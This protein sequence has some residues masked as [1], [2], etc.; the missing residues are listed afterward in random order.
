[1]V[2]LV[3][4]KLGQGS[5]FD[6]CR[7]ITAQISSVSRDRLLTQ[8]RGSLPPAPVLAQIYRNWR[9]LYQTFYCWQRPDSGDSQ[10]S[11]LP[12]TR[13][14][15]IQPGGVTHFSEVEFY[16][17]CQQFNKQLNQ[18]LN[19]E[20]F[21]PIYRKIC[22]ELDADEEIRLILETDDALLRQIPWHLW[23]FFRD[24]PKAE[25][26]LSSLEYRPIQSQA[27]KPDRR[28]KILGILGNSEGIDLNA[29]RKAIEDLPGATPCFLESPSHRQF[30]E[31]LWDDQWDI[32]FFAGHSQTE[33]ETGTGRIQINEVTSLSLEQLRNA[34][35]RA[36]SRGLKLAIFNSCDGLGLAKELADLDLPQVIVMREQVPDQVAQEFFKHFLAAFS[37]GQS[38]FSAV[39]EARERLEKLEDDYPCATW[40]PVICQN[41]T[42]PLADWEQWRG[43][44][45]AAPAESRSAQTSPLQIPKVLF[46]SLAITLG[47]MGLRQFGVLQGWEL[48]AYDHLMQKQP[49]QSQDHRFLIVTVTEEDLKSRPTQKSGADSLPDAQLVKLLERLAPLQP[50]TIGLDIFRPPGGQPMPSELVKQLQSDLFFGICQVDTLDDAGHSEIAPPVFLPQERQGFSDVILDPDR[51]LRRSLLAMAPPPASHCQAEYALS[52]QLAF[53][54]L[55]QQGV[56]IDYTRDNELRLGNTIIE[57]LPAPAKGNPL[58]SFFRS[59]RGGYQRVDAGG[60]QTLLKYRSAPLESFPTVTLQTVLQG[61]L[62]PED[63]KGRI[64]LI[65]VTADSFKDLHATP[66]HLLSNVN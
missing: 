65:G 3:V 15:K 16:N 1:M 12:S 2:R 54:Y 53:H 37:G 20:S 17:L 18:W 62:N 61:Q 8:Y 39:R 29:D 50:Q 57:R 7:D 27:R 30:N 25:L 66:Y 43:P 45:P 56:A 6:G 63:V 11:H 58:L 49:E 26:A 34:L 55:E 36:I 9:L 31:H 13:E 10:T 14:I 59:R 40:L 38:L 41:P 64:V 52:A 60:Y 21:Q 42:V 24:Y 4:I 46:T 47:V 5:L 48:R 23:E 32:L 28:V 33:A 51:V 35:T 19:S 22:Q 44:A